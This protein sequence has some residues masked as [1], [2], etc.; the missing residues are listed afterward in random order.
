MVGASPAK[1]DVKAVYKVNCKKCHGWDG[2][3][4]TPMGKMKKITDWTTATFQKQFTDAQIVDTILN[5]N[6]RGMVALKGKVSPAEAQALVKVVRA[7]GT[8]PGPFPEEK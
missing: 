6:S 8:A 1:A 5:G 7:F 4:N 2:K 3:A